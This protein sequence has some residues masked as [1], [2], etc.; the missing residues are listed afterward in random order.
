MS[1]RALGA[2]LAP[3]L[4]AS[5]IFSRGSV[6]SY[7]TEAGRPIADP[8]GDDAYLVWHD[9]AGWHLRARTESGQRFEGLVEGG[10]RR[11]TPV[12]VAP[13]ALRAERG[14]VAFSFV[15]EPGAPEAGFDWQGGCADFSLYVGGDSRP[16]RVFAGAYGASPP[17][18]PFSLCP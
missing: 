13:E 4:L 17:R 9:G 2:V 14:A 15:G 11:V 1:R 18:V 16:L 5:C 10:V 8:A 6:H 7:R 3:F 12:G